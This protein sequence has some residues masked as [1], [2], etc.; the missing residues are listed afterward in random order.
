MT[1]KPKEVVKKEIKF[2]I[3]K[4]GLFEFWRLWLTA[5]E[6]QNPESQ[7]M[8]MSWKRPTFLLD[9]GFTQL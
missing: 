7:N 5:H 3:P 6:N 9:I 4:S 2:I 8:T 1:H